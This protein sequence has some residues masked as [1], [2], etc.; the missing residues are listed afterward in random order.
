MKQY[1]HIVSKLFY[2]PL[3]VTRARHAAICK[4]VDAHMARVEAGDAEEMEEKCG[5]YQVGNTAVIPIHGTIVRHAS[6]IPMSACGCGLDD[7]SAMIDVAESDPSVKRIIFDFNTPGGEVTGTPEVARKIL[8]ISKPTIGYTS[9]E[10]CSGGM[11]LGMQC[12]YFYAA[13]S[14]SV[15]SIGVWCAYMDLSA[16]MAQNGER[17][18]EFH[19]GKFKTAGAWWKPMTTEEQA[20]VQARVDKIYLQFKEAVNSRREIP[21]EYMQGQIFDGEEGVRAG[22][23]DGIVDDLPELLDD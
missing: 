1:P 11:W 8:S 9:S 21:D 3:I 20:M 7:V 14:A 6:D 18:Q 17:M 5:Y 4:V 10:C 12:Q 22:L 2:E 13:A 23:V 16:Q 19:A 15:G